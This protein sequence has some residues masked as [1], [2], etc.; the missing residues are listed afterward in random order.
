MSSNALLIKNGTIITPD[1]VLEAHSVF[2]KDGKIAEIS[3]SN[4]SYLRERV[5]EIDAR[6]KMVCPGLINI[7]LHGGGGH[8]ATEGTCEAIR[9]IAITHA[10]FGTTSIL[11]TIPGFSDDARH[12]F[13]E[14]AKSLM[15]SGTGGAEILGVNWETPFI[16]EKF[17]GAFDKRFIQAPSIDAAR[18]FFKETLGTL[19]IVTIAP[20]LSGA[21]EVIKYFRDNGVI[22]SLGHSNATFNE[23]VAGIKAGASLGTHIFN[24]SSGLHHRDPGLVGALLI[25]PEITA[26]L[27]ADGYHVHPVSA[28]VV[29]RTKGVGHIILV[30]DSIEV[31]GTNLTEFSLVS[32]LN[33]KI[34]DGRTWGPEGQLIGSILTLDTAVRNAKL[35]FG[36][37]WDQAIK[38]ATSVPAETLG[39]GKK[40]GR[41]QI[42]SD[43][44]VIIVDDDFVV[45]STIVGG[46]IVYSK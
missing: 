33:V 18:N 36:I 16:N 27:I 2:I 25:S 40:K 7:H 37:N 19:R 35:W 21:L 42:G 41:L 29:F 34:H 12:R 22:V 30:T 10:K 5:T 44:D 28:E 24:A 15:E 3:P 43:A 20:E 39:L 26:E 38:M 9:Q 4:K 17:A 6:G 8:D 11:P 14:S 32:G 31:T 1:H 23:A 13:F 46:D 45:H